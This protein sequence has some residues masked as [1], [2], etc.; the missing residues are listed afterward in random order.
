MLTSYNGQAITYDQIGNPLSD[1]TWN[2]TWEYG[3]QLAAQSS[4]NTTWTY[5]YD[6]SGQ[7]ISRT[8][9]NTTY[10][11][12]Y[13]GSTLVY[14]KITQ[15]NTTVAEMYITYGE[16]GPLY[17]EYNGT[18]Y[19]Y[20]LNAQGDVVGLTE[21]DVTPAVLYT[22]NAWGELESITGNLAGTLG[23]HNP[24]RYRGYVYDT[25]TEQYY[26]NSRYY[27]PEWGRFINADD[28][29][30]CG[31]PGSITNYNLYTYCQNNPINY[32]D[33][34]G[35]L[36]ASV[37]RLTQAFSI[38]ALFSAYAS[39][40]YTA[41]SATLAKISLY[42]TGVLLPKITAMFWWQPWAIAGIVSAAVVIVITAVTVYTNTQ[43]AKIN[44]SNMNKTVEEILKTK[45]GSI[46]NAPLPPGG[47]SWKDILKK[48]L[49]EI[50]ELAQ[51]GK[52]GYKEIYKL[53]TDARFN[54]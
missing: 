13:Y 31:A 2:Y 1:D 28:I 18:I 32:Y 45:K 52:K 34:T 42:V 22:Y 37:M 14:E 54:R 40:L 12:G 21:W 29:A 35:Y 43:V 49:R 36:A 3:R 46:K 27:N 5:D 11:Y 50:K 9:N 25:E 33:S 15:G 48:T 24:L 47:P 44:E 4:G 16:A 38:S 23:V 39:G 51:K 6:A 10:E 7:R 30:F 17:I 41:F 19:Y 8:D 20:M 53:L 26:L